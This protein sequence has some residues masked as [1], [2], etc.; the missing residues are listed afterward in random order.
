[1]S[2]VMKL[3]GDLACQKNS[4]LKSLTVTVLKCEAAAKEHESW[5]KSAVEKK[6]KSEWWVVQVDDTVLFPEGGGQPFDTGYIGDAYCGNVQR[7]GMEVFHLVDQQL[8]VNKEMEMKLDWSRR[9]DQMQQHTGQHL[10]TA[11]MEQ[12]AGLETMCWGMG[13]ETSYIQL[14]SAKVPQEKLDAVEEKCNEFIRDATAVSVA[15]KVE[16]QKVEDARE[17]KSVP[18]GAEGGVIRYVDINGVDACTCC[19]THVKHLAHLQSMKLLHYEPKGD[20]CRLY[21]VTGE[22]VNKLLSGCYDRERAIIKLLG[23]N[24]DDL[25]NGIKRVQKTAATL[26]KSHAS[27]LKS[28][29]PLVGDQLVQEMKEKGCNNKLLFH[30]RPDAD[31]PYMMTVAEKVAASDPTT[32]AV[33]TQGDKKGGEGQMLLSCKSEDRLKAAAEKATTVLNAKGGAGKGVWRGKVPDL[34][35]MKDFEKLEL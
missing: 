35:L 7:K 12:I 4:Y 26:K 1:M 10:L 16:A 21:F 22:R 3:A 23:T 34:K 9:W 18:E 27:A 29:S 6:G 30:H 5:V 15:E 14:P 20:T 19:G 8:E 32:L 17:S 28:L 31:M 2:T 11:V 33:L 25:E 13:K 24:A